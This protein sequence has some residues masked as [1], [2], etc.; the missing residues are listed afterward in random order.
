MKELSNRV[1]AE[2][3][4]WPIPVKVGFKKSHP[5]PICDVRAKV[6]K[7]HAIRTHFP[8]ALDENHI[9]GNV[10]LSVYRNVLQFFCTELNVVDCLALIVLV[11]Q[12]DLLTT[13]EHVIVDKIKHVS[14]VL[15]TEI[16]S[17]SVSD[18]QEL[19]HWRTICNLLVLLSSDRQVLLREVEGS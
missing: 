17:M 18:L 4:G 5:C 16:P 13:Q 10:L 11:K 3:I 7:T 15:A 14:S 2:L 19:L 12:K 9:E 6:V 8:K 1:D